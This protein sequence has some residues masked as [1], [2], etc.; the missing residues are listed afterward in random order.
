MG[1][2]CR[3]NLALHSEGTVWPTPTPRRLVM[4]CCAYAVQ[5]PSS[6]SLRT[7]SDICLDWPSSC[8]L[9]TSFHR[10][11]QET[12]QW[13]HDVQETNRQSDSDHARPF[14]AA[15]LAWW[16]CSPHAFAWAPLVAVLSGT[17]G[18]CFCV[19]SGTPSTRLWMRPP[20]WLPSGLT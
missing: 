16:Y 3:W 11:N 8:A 19:R 20:W 1:A 9:A 15:L 6:V 18:G 4:T 5:R 13:F 12:S 10:R 14:Y 2:S 7:S 17:F